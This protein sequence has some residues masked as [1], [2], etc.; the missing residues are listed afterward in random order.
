VIEHREEVSPPWCFRLRRRSSPDGLT[1]MRGNVLHRLVPGL[2]HEPVHV[3]VAQTA[4]DAVLIGARARTRASARTAIGRMRF[5]LAVDD[6]LHPFHVR[7]RDDALIGGKLRTKRSYRPFRQPDPFVA[8]AWTIVEQKIRFS[9]A[10]EII[11]RIVYRLGRR[12]PA[13]GLWSPP[14][15]AALA[16][17][18]SPRL[19][20]FGLGAP[21]A[22]ALSLAAREVAAGRIDLAPG[23]DHEAAW[24]RLRAIP[25][26]GSWTVEMTAIAG[27]G[28]YDQVPA[29]DVGLLKLV[30]RMRTGSPHARA[31][32]D[33]VRALFAPYGEWA[34]LASLVAMSPGPLRRRPTAPG[35]AGTRSS[36]RRPHWADA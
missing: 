31:D 13:T 22:R 36:A 9:E 3:R 18:T 26:I 21:R 8:L 27:Q 30:G 4:P 34:G 2:E 25:G 5:A 15:A 28:R 11:R 29:G 10:A 20:S 1:R 16:A 17:A 19:Q 24:R 6:D 14:D 23:G 35:R 12:D 7:F 33:E 32:E